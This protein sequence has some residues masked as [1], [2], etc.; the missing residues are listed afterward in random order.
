MTSR[1]KKVRGHLFLAIIRINGIFV[2]C[3]FSEIYEN[4]AE[5]EI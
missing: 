4:I 1:F 2:V 3:Y 5:N